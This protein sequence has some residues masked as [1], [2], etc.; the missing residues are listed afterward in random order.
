MFI[1]PFTGVYRDNPRQYSIHSRTI[2]V[3]LSFSGQFYCPL[4]LSHTS[5]RALL[6][7]ICEF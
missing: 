5:L 6:V 3:R 1:G 7:A 2:T 4:P